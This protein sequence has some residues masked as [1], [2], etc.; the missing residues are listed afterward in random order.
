MGPWG[1]TNQGSSI[2]IN[3]YTGKNKIPPKKGSL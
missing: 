3:K 2:E 1:Q